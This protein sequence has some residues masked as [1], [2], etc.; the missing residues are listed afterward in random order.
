MVAGRAAHHV[1]DR[2]AA[3]EVYP[4]QPLLQR[5]FRSHRIVVA[6]QRGAAAARH[7]AALQLRGLVHAHLVSAGAAH[8]RVQLLELA[9]PQRQHLDQRG[10]AREQVAAAPQQGGAIILALRREHRIQER[11]LV[12]LLPVTHQIHRVGPSQAGAER[13]ELAHESLPEAVRQRPQAAA[14]ADEPGHGCHVA[15]PAAAERG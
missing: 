11:A 2:P 5:H 13:T 10:G 4:A 6:A 9:R 15:R 7:G 1:A 8:Q 12:R 3:E 14:A